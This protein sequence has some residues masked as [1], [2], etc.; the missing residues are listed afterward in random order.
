MEKGVGG[1][2][3]GAG[4]GAGVGKKGE[5]SNNVPIQR[6]RTVIACHPCK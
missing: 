3:G 4:A 5:V 1:G 6:R 2:K